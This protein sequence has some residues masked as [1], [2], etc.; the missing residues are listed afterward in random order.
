MRSSLR[1]GAIVLAGTLALQISVEPLVVQF[2]LAPGGQVST[3]VTV[4]NTG[5]EKAVVTA[6]QID[7]RT[8]LDGAMKSER[9]GTEGALSLNP[10]FSPLYA[11]R[12]RTALR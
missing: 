7:W 9:P 1:T 10:H 2:S 11:P 3:P 5:S 6:S 4:R 12:A 8:T